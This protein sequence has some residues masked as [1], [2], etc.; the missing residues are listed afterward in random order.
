MT[1]AWWTLVSVSDLNGMGCNTEHFERLWY[2]IKR[3]KL[4][5]QTARKPSVVTLAELT[6]NSHSTDGRWKRARYIRVNQC[7]S[8]NMIPLHVITQRDVLRAVC[9]QMGLGQ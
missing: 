6:R 8:P 5:V 7:I 3:F 1:A 9:N 2:P 4:N